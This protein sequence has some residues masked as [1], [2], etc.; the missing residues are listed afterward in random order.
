M[1]VHDAITSNTTKWVGTA[2]G[3]KPA[4]PIVNIPAEASVL[5][6][7]VLDIAY[8]SRSLIKQIVGVSM[9]IHM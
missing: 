3:T 5:I 9:S 4:T 1:I 7:G 6:V 8:N 2:S